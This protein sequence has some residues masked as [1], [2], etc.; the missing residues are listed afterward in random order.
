[1]EEGF[2]RKQLFIVSFCYHGMLGG[3]IIAD[4]DAITY[5]AGKLTI[6]SEYRNLRMKYSD[7][8]YVYRDK[9]ALLPAVSIHMKSGKNYKFVI[10]FARKRFFELMRSKGVTVNS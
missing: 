3:D 5:K 7:I 8:A 1:M 6:K 10:F 9:A 4:E 2:M